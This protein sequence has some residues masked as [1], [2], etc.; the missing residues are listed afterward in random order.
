MVMKFGFQE[1]LILALLGVIGL[2]VVGG[3]VALLVL[4]IKGKKAQPRT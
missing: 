3:I 1:L 4:L 2:V